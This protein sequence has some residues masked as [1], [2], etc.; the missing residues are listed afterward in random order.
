MNWTSRLAGFKQ[1]LILCFSFLLATLLFPPLLRAETPNHSVQTPSDVQY[2]KMIEGVLK[3]T[4]HLIEPE[5]WLTLRT[6]LSLRRGMLDNLNPYHPA[7]LNSINESLKLTVEGGNLYL[8]GEELDRAQTLLK[9]AL[10]K[11]SDN[12]LAVLLLADL[13]SLK[14]KRGEAIHYYLGFWE[15]FK[16]GERSDLM[17][18][19]FS[20]RDKTRASKHTAQQLKSY[21]FEPPKTE[22]TDF[23]PFFQNP[24]VIGLRPQKLR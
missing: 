20:R 11:Y 23:F 14:G 9:E 19:L 10:K 15:E 3:Q 18:F 12:P 2:K 22:R 1:I 4:A 17:P 8:K 24:K 5:N 6:K 7:L 16:K 21:G 13:F